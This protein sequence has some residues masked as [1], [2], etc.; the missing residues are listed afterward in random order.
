MLDR[1]TIEEIIHDLKYN[2]DSNVI[3][4]VDKLMFSFKEEVGFDIDIVLV[5]GSS[6]IRRVAKALEV[7][8]KIHKPIVLSG[9]IKT[10]NGVSESVKFRDYLIEYG[11]SK[12]LV[13]VEDTSLNTEENFVNSFRLINNIFYDNKKILLITSSQHMLRALLTAKRVIENSNYSFDIY[14]CP[15]FPD[16]IK[17]DNWYLKQETIDIVIGEFTRLI[18]YGLVK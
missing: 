11:V 1:S 12:E 2:L 10:F 9:G 15:S 14:T 8:Q 5:L 3:D 4:Q 13:Y 17:R 6:S 18:K 16:M 7:Y